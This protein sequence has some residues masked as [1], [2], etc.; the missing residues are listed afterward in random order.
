M[1]K[2]VVISGAGLSVES[3]VQAF[4]GKE[5]LWCGHDIAKVATGST[6]LA[7]AVEIR[8]FY[9]ARR[10]EIGRA[11]PNAAHHLLAGLEGSE[12]F[13]LL[14]F[15]QNVDDL[16][17][18]AGAAEVVHLHGSIRRLRC[19]MCGQV[20]DVG[21]RRIQSAICPTC[22]T[23]GFVRPDIVF[24]GEH[25]PEYARLRSALQSL[26]EEDALVVIGTSGSVL[27]VGEIAKHVPG[28]RILCDPN[29]SAE[30]DPRAFHEVVRLPA[31]EGMAKVLDLIR[32]SAGSRFPAGRWA[33]AE[34]EAASGPMGPARSGR[35]AAL[36][37]WLFRRPQPAQC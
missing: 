37:A 4:R 26:G 12:E 31:S 22:R 15:T 24:M 17:E 5:G 30:I 36:L 34:E 27:S 14:H 2:V 25:A 20:R 33:T 11:E 28:F 23:K 18:R 6:W 9:N 13:G 7:N 8:D 16:L 19:E 29:P 35:M 1:R 32:A 10:Y 21:H 3:G